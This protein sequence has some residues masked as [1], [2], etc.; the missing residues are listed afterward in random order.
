MK[1]TLKII[2][3]SIL[4]LILFRGFFY[5]LLIKYSEI[6]IRTEIKITHQDLIKKIETKSAD[7]KI[8]VEKIISIANSITNEELRFTG[9]RASR[10]PNELINTNRANCTGY[11]AMFNSIANYLIHKNE[12][13]KKIEA[14]HLIGRLEFLGIDL[15]QFFESPFFRDHD[16][17]RKVIICG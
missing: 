6:G 1:K 7:K 9:S 17:N 4:I 15:H 12:L 16:F 8:D 2:G 13:E 11:S 5:R 10:N 3:I 14:R